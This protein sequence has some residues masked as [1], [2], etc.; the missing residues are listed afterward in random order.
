MFGRQFMCSSAQEITFPDIDLL[1][2][3]MNQFPSP[4]DTINWMELNSVNTTHLKWHAFTKLFTAV[5][6]EVRQAGFECENNWKFFIS[7]KAKRGRRMESFKGDTGSLKL[8]SSMVWLC[9]LFAK[10][11]FTG[12]RDGEQDWDI[13]L[14]KHRTR[15]RGRNHERKFHYIFYLFFH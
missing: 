2:W 12:E 10:E 1:R 4:C 9:W 14:R 3:K 5:S 13:V 15:L 11:N 7:E 8:N 6:P